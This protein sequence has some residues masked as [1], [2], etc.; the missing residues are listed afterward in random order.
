[1]NSSIPLPTGDSCLFLDVDGTLIEFSTNPSQTAA[2]RALKDLLITVSDALDGAVALVSGR[3]IEDLD[4]IFFPLRLP[5]AGVHGGE[6]RTV[7]DLDPPH[8][9]PDMRLDPAR[10]CLRQFCARHPN[11]VLEDKSI[12]V[13]VHFRNEPA[14]AAELEHELRPILA[15]LGPAFH[16]LHGS[17]VIEIKPRYFTKAR[18][19]EDFLRQPPFKNRTPIF[20]GDDVT[21]LDG[22]GLIEERHGTSIAVGDRVAAQWRLADPAAAREWLSEFAAMSTP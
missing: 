16:A 7:R 17:M 20:L 15:E 11:V 22:F 12:A 21:D 14:A 19:I 3:R 18:A 5:A 1:M 8:L 6:R 9:P 13:A 10:E 4:R 2:T